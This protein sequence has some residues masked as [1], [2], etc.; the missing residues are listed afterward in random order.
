M[1][2][3]FRSGIATSLDRTAKGAS[4]AKVKS[5][6]IAEDVKKMKVNELCV[7]LKPK[8]DE[9]HW[10]DVEP[11]IP[12]QRIKGINFLEYTHNH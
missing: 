3:G 5:K 12:N 1:A 6:V 8:L 2:V 10:N 4:E 11:V 9:E 7:W